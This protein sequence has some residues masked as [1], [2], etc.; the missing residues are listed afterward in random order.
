MKKSFLIFLS[1]TSEKQKNHTSEQGVHLFLYHKKTLSIS[2][3]M[4]KKGMVYWKQETVGSI[5]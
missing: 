4:E 2:Q 1:L 5:Q 3:I